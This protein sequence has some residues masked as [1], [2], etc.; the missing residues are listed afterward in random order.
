MYRIFVLV[1]FPI[2]LQYLLLCAIVI[3]KDLR[4]VS[5]PSVYM[6]LS[7]C[8]E[9]DNGASALSLF[10]VFLSSLVRQSFTVSL[11]HPLIFGKNIFSFFLRIVD[12]S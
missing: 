9:E 12:D 10:K 7:C 5:H 4:T 1:H 6:L 3:D 2:V 11:N 8:Y